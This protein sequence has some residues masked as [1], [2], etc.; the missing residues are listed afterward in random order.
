MF[1]GCFGDIFSCKGKGCIF[2]NIES[3]KCSVFPISFDE[4]QLL[5]I[6][7]ASDGKRIEVRVQ[8]IGI[9]FAIGMRIGESDEV[10]ICTGGEE[11]RL[12]AVRAVNIAVTFI[13]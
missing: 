3:Y 8:Y 6:F 2:W 13:S 4:T 7:R 9:L 5:S 10:L 12:R 1:I 11:F